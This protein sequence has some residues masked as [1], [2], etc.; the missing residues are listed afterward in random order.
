MSETPPQSPSVVVG[1]DGSRL[2]LNAALWAVD[3]AIERDLPLRLVY[4][5][6]PQDGPT[7]P[8]T[9][10]RALAAADIAV[11]H[12]FVVIESTGKP[13]KIEVEILQGRPTDKLLEASRAAAL[14]C[15]GAVGVKHATEG[16]IGSTA[17][18]LASR[19]HCPIAVVHGFDPAPHDP[20]AIVVEVES[21]ADGQAV[22]QRGIDEALL[23][24][25]PLV[26]LAVWHPEVTDVHDVHATAE[27]NR[28]LT[29]DLNARLARTAR[30]HPELEV[31]PVAVRGGL[32]NYLS[33]HAQST[34]LVVVGLRRLHGVSDVLGPRGFAALHGT[35][36]AMLICPSNG[37]L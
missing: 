35:G 5:I 24:G 29:A 6:E 11:R 23:R 2:A 3:E 22:L 10:A 17:A 7:D 34:Q 33:R 12:A 19:A 21:S 25:A 26:V 20:K 9:S 36:C 8:E 18:G 1:I 14:A 27:Q 28:R 37:H 30:R 15:V 16:P 32:L 13:V 4:V 31:R